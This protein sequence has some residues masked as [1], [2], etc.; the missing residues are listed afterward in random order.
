MGYVVCAGERV[1]VAS[2]GPSPHTGGSGRSVIPTAHRCFIGKPRKPCCGHGMKAALVVLI[3]RHSQQQIACLPVVPI[4]KQAQM[5]NVVVCHLSVGRCEYAFR[6]R[7]ANGSPRVRRGKPWPV[8]GGLTAGRAPP[9]RPIGADWMIPRVSRCTN[10]RVIPSMRL[11][12]KVRDHAR[13]PRR[14]R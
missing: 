7:P 3:G 1:Q 10:A 12:T 13:R 11:H 5:R 9:A 14:V 4:G 8:A 6:S 2:P